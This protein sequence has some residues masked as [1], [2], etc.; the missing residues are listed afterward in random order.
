MARGM[1][2]GGCG[3]RVISDMVIADDRCGANRTYFDFPDR[4]AEGIVSRLHS[5]EMSPL[6]T[7]AGPTLLFTHGKTTLHHSSKRIQLRQNEA[8]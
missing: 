3:E 4:L 1:D 6:T 7:I 8:H 2:G 5:Q